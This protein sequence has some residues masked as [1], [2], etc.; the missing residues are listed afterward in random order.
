[1]SGRED[2]RRSG[3]EKDEERNQTEKVEI[4]MNKI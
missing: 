3:S 2:K 1:M 4:R